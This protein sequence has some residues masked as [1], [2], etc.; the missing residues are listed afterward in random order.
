MA[1]AKKKKKKINK[2]FTVA[3]TVTLGYFFL[4]EALKGH[5]RLLSVS[6]G[7]DVTDSGGPHQV[8]QKGLLSLEGVSL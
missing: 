3:R 5:L 7:A 2:T 6:S 4:W 1:F 8:Y